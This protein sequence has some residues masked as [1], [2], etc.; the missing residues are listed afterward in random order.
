MCYKNLNP[1]IIKQVGY[2][3]EEV[4]GG[5]AEICGR[6]NRFTEYYTA[7]TTNFYID[8]LA[9]VSCKGCVARDY[10]TYDKKIDG[11]CSEEYKK[12]KAI[13]YAPFYKVVGK[14][15]NE[16]LDNIEKKT[17]PLYCASIHDAHSMINNYYDYQNAIKNFNTF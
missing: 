1:S 3:S 2:W 5:D 10:C 11:E 12:M 17:R 6:I 4:Y 8:I 14:K 16:F 9:S 7:I 15:T 13:A